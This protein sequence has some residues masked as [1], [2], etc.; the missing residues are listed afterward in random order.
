MIP[1][2]AMQQPRRCFYPQ[3]QPHCYYYQPQP[4]QEPTFEDVMHEL[5]DAIEDMQHMTFNQCPYRTQRRADDRKCS[6]R[7][8]RPG[9]CKR[10]RKCDE[11]TRTRDSEE[12]AP[13]KQDE[14][15][16]VQ[17]STDAAQTPKKP[18]VREVVTSHIDERIV[19]Q[20]QQESVK[21]VDGERRLAE[22]DARGIAPDDIKVKTNAADGVIR[23]ISVTLRRRYSTF[24]FGQV[25]TERTQVLPVPEGVEADDIRSFMTPD[26]TL[27]IALKK[28][29]VEEPEAAR[30]DVTKHDDEQKE[31]HYV[32]MD[33]D[34][35]EEREEEV[36]TD[37]RESTE[38]EARAHVDGDD[39]FEVVDDETRD[40]TEVARE[41][42]D[43]D[44]SGSESA[45]QTDDVVA[46]VAMRG[47]DASDVSVRL[48]EDGRSVEVV[49]EREKRDEDGVWLHR[50]VRSIP[51]KREGALA[52]VEHRVDDDGTVTVIA[53]E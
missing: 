2:Y 9:Q 6:R 26:D 15:R 3:Q 53:K 20:Q 35:M 41:K 44:V 25:T 24:F 22:I 36:A 5:G 16:D 7:Q 39:S 34:V 32:T 40:A 52:R 51:L 49:G 21:D 30:D 10:G 33:D 29:R 45:K 43:A 8:Q 50:V 18:E 11:T 37:E 23:F 28:E 27:V 31:Q 47:F 42:S 1:S 17:H 48:A 19:K 38:L 46:R 13:L 12:K 4:M 14:R